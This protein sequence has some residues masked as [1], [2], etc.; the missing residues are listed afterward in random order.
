[1]DAPEGVTAKT[2]INHYIQAI[3]GRKNLENVKDISEV[4]SAS[5]RGTDITIITKKKSPDKYMMAH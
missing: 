5:I 1:M 3:G 4:M 2:V